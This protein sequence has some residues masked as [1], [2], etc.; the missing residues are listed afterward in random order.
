MGTS[1]KSTKDE[2]LKENIDGKL[3]CSPRKILE[4]GN[5]EKCLEQGEAREADKCQGWLTCFVSFYT[6]F[7]C[8]GIHCNFGLFHRVLVSHYQVSSASTGGFYALW[9]TIY[10]KL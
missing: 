10:K 2:K 3:T 6:G 7:I 1:T 4:D 9:A 8:F 5:Y